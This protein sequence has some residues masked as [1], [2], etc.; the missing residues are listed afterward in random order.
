[1]KAADASPAKQRLRAARRRAAARQRSRPTCSQRDGPEAV[2]ELLERVAAVRALPRRA[3]P[4]RGRPRARPRA[5]TGSSTQLRPGVRRARARAR[6][7]RSSSARS[8]AASRVSEKLVEQPARRAR[9]R[10]AGV[11][12][13][14]A[15]RTRHARRAASAPSARS[16]SCAS[17][18]PS[19]A[20]ELL[21]E[22]DLDALFASPLTRAAAAHLRD[23]PRARR[24]P[25]STTARWRRC[26]PSSRSAPAR[27]RRSRAELEVERR[28]LELARLERAIA[29]ARGGGGGGPDRARQRE[30]ETIKRELDGWLDRGARADRRAARL[31]TRGCST[32][33]LVVWS[34]WSGRGGAGART[35]PGQPFR[36]SSIGRALGC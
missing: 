20:R 1:M 35:P 9:A 5:A 26:S 36:G 16:S 28:Q 27:S 15:R 31:T 11:R 3:D 34:N 18:C 30:R 23:A 4:R 33:P 12:R 29:G 21:D 10:G 14:S 25:G 6:C 32:A 24:R 17:R 2:R 13:P 22:L 8:S 7:A 19:A